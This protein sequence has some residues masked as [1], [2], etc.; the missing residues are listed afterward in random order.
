MKMQ[1]KK[2]RC[3]HWGPSAAGT[4]P[5]PWLASGDDSV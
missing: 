2:M 3:A 4:Q 5:L 1:E